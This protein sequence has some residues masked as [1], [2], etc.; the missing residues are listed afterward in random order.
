MKLLVGIQTGLEVWRGQFDVIYQIL[1]GYAHVPQ[2]YFHTFVN[3]GAEFGGVGG[4]T[5]FKFIPF[6]I[7]IS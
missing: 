5:F 7:C 6:Y 3:K 4:H 2:I 1:N